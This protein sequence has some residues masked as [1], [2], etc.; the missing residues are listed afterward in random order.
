MRPS[1]PPN[2]GA[3]RHAVPQ[4]RPQRLKKAEVK[5]ERRFDLI[6]LSLSLN[7]NL[8]LSLA[9][10]FSILLDDSPHRT[11]RAGGIGESRLSCWG[12]LQ[13]ISISAIMG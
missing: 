8:S 7:L 3:P 6:H 12:S 5:V 10:F 13:F 11:W 2:P 4:A 9:D 1:H